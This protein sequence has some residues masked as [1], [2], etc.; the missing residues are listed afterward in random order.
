MTEIDDK[1]LKQFFQEQKQEIADDGF[2]RRVK[3]QLPDRIRKL[4]NAWVSLCSAIA[5]V[6]F[7]AFDGL[8]ILF[9]LLQQAYI[10]IVQFFATTQF[11]LRTWCIVVVILLFAG[12]SRL[13][14][15][16]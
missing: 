2:S 10:S 3:A 6:L 15:M 4:S 8:N 1:L 5:I 16:E 7:F 13:F 9:N 14:S 11:D 12:M